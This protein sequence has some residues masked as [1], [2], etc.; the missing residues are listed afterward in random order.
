MRALLSFFLSI[1]I[2]CVGCKKTDQDS[3]SSDLIEHGTQEQ[4]I[5][6]ALEG[7]SGGLLASRFASLDA[8][9]SVVQIEYFKLDE[10]VDSAYKG[11]AMVRLCH[12]AKGMHIVSELTSGLSQKDVVKARDGGVKDRLGLLVQSPYSVARRGELRKIYMLSRWV[13]TQFGE[14]DVA[15]FNLAK[16]AV[17]HINTEDLAYK[18]SR[19]SSEKGYL[20]TFNHFIAQAIITS[21]FS[22]ELA[23]FLADMHELHN[24]PE[25]PT[26]V[27]SEEQ[28]V[29]SNNN[30]I[31]NYVDLINNEWGQ[32]AGK[33]L[34]VK[35]AITPKTYWTPGLL[36]N[37]LNDLQHCFSWTF[38]IGFQPFREEDEVVIRFAHK[39]N[40]AIRGGS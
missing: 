18:V 14:G 13:P 39:M 25:L 21:C 28:L 29:D 23:D 17:E 36:A 27:F 22:E 16:T 33:Y 32:E 10:H 1:L 15:F 34:Q 31:D 26:G 20:N 12:H 5:D 24:M 35:Y 8:F 4:L 40:V 19:D 38:Q 7:F 30:P 2:F 3:V 6:T 37:Y 9:K 11:K